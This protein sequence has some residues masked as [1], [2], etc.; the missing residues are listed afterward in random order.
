MDLREHLDQ[1]GVRYEW[2]KHRKAHS[3]QSLALKEDV[4]AEN[5]IKPV[6]VKIDGEFVLCALPASCRVDLGRLQMELGAEETRLADEKDLSSLCTDCELGAEPPIGWLFGL[7]TLMDE[8]IFD[9][10]TVTFQAG[11]H[12]DA[13]TMKVMDYYRLAKPVVGHFGRH[14]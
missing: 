8:S 6:L 7:P 10:A 14:L 3:A 9:D 5:V 2:L 4:P 12:R 13:V 1:L 11:T